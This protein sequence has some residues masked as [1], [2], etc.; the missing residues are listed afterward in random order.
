V[1]I[2]V[3]NIGERLKP[4]A[5]EGHLKRG[6]AVKARFPSRTGSQI[7]MGGLGGTPLLLGRFA[8]RAARSS[9]RAA[10]EGHR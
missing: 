9:Q 8:S 7:L 6:S 5:C 10:R 4:A 3:S 1:H 2:L